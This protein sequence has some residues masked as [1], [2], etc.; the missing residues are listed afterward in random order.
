MPSS[1]IK[2]NSVRSLKFRCTYDKYY[3]F[4][5][6]RG[7]CYGDGD[8]GN[9]L[10]SDIS[11]NGLPIGQLS[12]TFKD[13]DKSSTTG[14]EVYSKDVMWEEA[15]NVGTTLKD[16]GLTGVDNGFVSYKRDQISNRD[17]INIFTGTTYTIP[18][19]EQRFFMSPVS[20]NTNTF[21]YPME[22]CEDENG[23]YFAMKGG[24]YQGY[25]K[26]HGF[27][28]QTLPNYIDDEWNMSFQIRRKDYETDKNILNTLH[29]E[30]KGIF[31]YM[32]TR[33][34]N[35]FWELYNNAED[36]AE[37]LVESADNDG[38]CEDWDLQNHVT[39]YLTYLSDEGINYN[40][41]YLM[42]N[43]DE[44][45]PWDEEY[46]KIKLGEYDGDYLYCP[47]IEYMDIAWDEDY[48][49]GET[50]GYA[51][52]AEYWEEDL[53]L[54]TVEIITS[55]G[56]ELDKRGYYEIQTD[57]KFLFFNRTCT[58][59]TVNKWD[60]EEEAFDYDSCADKLTERDN[61]E[62]IV[63]L[64]GR[65]DNC[66]ENKFI[67]YNR[68]CTGKTVNN[69]MGRFIITGKTGEGY[70]EYAMDSYEPYDVFKDIKNNSFALRVDEEGRIGYRFGMLD[71]DEP[72][73]HYSIKE[74][75][76]KKCLVCKDR[77]TNVHLRIKILNPSYKDCYTHDEEG[78][79][80]VKKV[81]QHIGERKMKIYIYV[82]GYLVLV[83]EELP[84]FNFRELDDVAQ[85]QEGVPFS[86]SLGGGSQGLLETISKDYYHTSE[87]MLPI[88]KYFGGTFIGDIRYFRFYNCFMDYRKIR[89]M[90]WQKVE[91]CKNC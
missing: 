2:N 85:K 61:G 54:K 50:E 31:F 77:W 12:R 75:Y 73:H 81:P 78:N 83:S 23:Q 64:N 13:G 6:Y 51:W 32:G 1:N 66:K 19:E 40:G 11:A 28:Y 25:Y 9:C 57:N 56:Y 34:E 35:K 43:I 91:D 8:F 3:D 27:D 21:K 29:P 14:G 42:E 36:K 88:E 16:I 53:D 76:S 82:D 45:C 49:K 26:L 44:T 84:E 80:I 46:W 74:E 10:V 59:F 62:P 67:T 52:D 58:G 15:V 33:A 63:S 47:D 90:T 71:C 79:L 7:E 72:L 37:F 48:W 39:E 69:A 41:D 38:Y 60:R 89:N 65:K 70:Y 18:E 4:M 30:N 68:T 17:F 20:G 5:L 87:Y 24:F 55:L 86:I 22:V